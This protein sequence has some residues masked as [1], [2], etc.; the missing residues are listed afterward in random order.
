MIGD[1]QRAAARKAWAKLVARAKQQIVEKVV[2]C[3]LIWTRP[4]VVFGAERELVPSLRLWHARRK[5]L[6]WGCLQNGNDELS[7]ITKNVLSA[8]RKA[9]PSVAGSQIAEQRTW[10]FRLQRISIMRNATV[11]SV[12]AK[13]SVVVY[14]GLLDKHQQPVPPPAPYPNSSPVSYDT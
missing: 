5:S 3:L 8:W 4:S 6:P 7:W 11:V 2:C 9:A 13:F 12:S 14:N 1:R 10:Q